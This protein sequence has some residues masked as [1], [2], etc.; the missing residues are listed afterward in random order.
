MM[1]PGRLGNRYVGLGIQTKMQKEKKK[2]RQKKV[3]L[4]EEIAYK[5]VLIHLNKY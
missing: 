3:K 4:K 5:M 1:Y 2:M